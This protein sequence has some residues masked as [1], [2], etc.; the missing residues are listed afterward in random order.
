MP[1]SSPSHVKVS[2]SDDGFVIRIEDH[3]DFRDSEV[4]HDVAEQCLAD[5]QSSVAVD[6]TDCQYLD[7]TFLGCLVDC[8]KRFGRNKPD[9]FALAGSREHCKSLMAHTRLEKV[10]KIIDRPPKTSGEFET[11]P[12]KPMT[13]LGVG[14]HV[15][16]CHRQL[17]EIEGPQRAV[18]AGIADRMQRELEEE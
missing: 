11:L 8:Y 3:G 1:D 7:S 17:A 4:F 18:F 10:L 16:E 6:L 12:L 5:G 15:L 2:R 9:Q 13:R 14:Q